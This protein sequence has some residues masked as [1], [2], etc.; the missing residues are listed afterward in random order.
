MHPHHPGQNQMQ[1][2]I[3]GQQQ[4]AYP[5]MQHLQPQTA[6]SQAVNQVAT[7]VESAARSQ[8]GGTQGNPKGG[9]AVGSKIA[10]PMGAMN[11]QQASQLNQFLGINNAAGSHNLINPVQ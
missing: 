5:A 8:G 6:G 2:V 9:A 1:A 7:G 10:G 11:P 4:P 3:G